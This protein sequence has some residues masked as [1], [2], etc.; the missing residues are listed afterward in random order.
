MFLYLFM[1]Y[2]YL[3]ILAAVLPA[4]I[5]LVKAY[6]A[7]RVEKE[8]IGLIAKLVG[9]GFLAVVCAIIT[10]TIGEYV[11]SL[12]V[13]PNSLTY[14]FLLYFI[15]VALSEEGFKYLFLKRMTWNNPNFDCLFDGVIYAISVSLGFALLENIEY[16]F[17]Y[18]MG[19][20]IARAFTAVPGHACF[21]VF[22][23][24]FYAT[25]RQLANRLDHAE[26]KKFR[27]YAV[28]VPTMVHGAYDFIA[29]SMDSSMSYAVFILFVL[30]M[31]IVAYKLVDN[32]SKNDQYI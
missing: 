20:A 19:T 29:T 31:F 27:F 26:S 32:F 7:D 6:Q 8:P 18:G 24:I 21:G 4:I 1:Q 22:M 17:M 23:G 5:L 15:V 2:S 14:N 16:T 13:K 25:A 12:F 28:L 3:L 10:E 9:G 30:I 11:L